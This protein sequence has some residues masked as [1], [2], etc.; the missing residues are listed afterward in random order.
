MPR[1]PIVPPDP[2][3]ET[4]RDDQ[5]GW[6]IAIFVAIVVLG[7]AIIGL[8][9]WGVF[10]QRPAEHRDVEVENAY[11]PVETCICV[12]TGCPAKTEAPKKTQKPVKTKGPVKTKTPTPAPT[13]TPQK[14]KVPSEELSIYLDPPIREETVDGE[15]FLIM[16]F[17]LTGDTSEV[18]QWSF[19]LNGRSE[20]WRVYQG[21]HRIEQR[22]EK[23]CS[24]TTIQPMIKLLD[25]TVITGTTKTW[26]PSN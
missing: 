13:K 1:P 5:K 18:A 14:T 11:S 24:K 7:L 17:A 19:K 21:N 6:I 20:P 15:T 23:P 12:K 16:T 22:I 3:E 9:V 26:T 2:D 10:F 4:P 25:G 8:I